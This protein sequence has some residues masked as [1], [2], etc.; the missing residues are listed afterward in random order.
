[1]SPKDDLND[2]KTT[3]AWNKVKAKLTPNLVQST[4]LPAEMSLP[5]VM[6]KNISDAFQAPVAFKKIVLQAAKNAHLFSD[7]GEEEVKPD[8]DIVPFRPTYTDFNVKEYVKPDYFKVTQ[9]RSYLYSREN[10]TQK[11]LLN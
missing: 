10:M 11:T 4:K 5:Q 6:V 3:N 8:V 2:S 7:N 9:S 1:M